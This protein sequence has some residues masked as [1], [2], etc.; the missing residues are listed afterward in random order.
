MSVVVVEDGKVVLTLRDVKDVT[1]ARAKYPRLVDAYLVD[2]D[3]PVDTA[4]AN[5]KFTK[6]TPPPFVTPEPTLITAIRELAEAV[7]PA[8]LTAFNARMGGGPGGGGAP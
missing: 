7:G 2:G 5:G 4:F 6:F 8:A 3:W 1:A